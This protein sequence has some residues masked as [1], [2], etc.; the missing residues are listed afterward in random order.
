MIG[1]QFEPVRKRLELTPEQRQIMLCV[2]ERNHAYYVSK[3]LMH[4]GCMWPAELLS[5]IVNELAHY[6]ANRPAEGGQA[7]KDGCLSGEATPAP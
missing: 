4:P 5:E 7:A 6:P 1:V 3:Y 2:L